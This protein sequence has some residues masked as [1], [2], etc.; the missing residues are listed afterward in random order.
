MTKKS[1]KYS[2][3][4]YFFNRF[5]SKKSTS[6]TRSKIKK[7]GVKNKFKFSWKKLRKYL[8]YGIVGI[9]LFVGILFAWY[10]KDLPTPSKLKSL[11][12][13]ESTKIYDR[14]GKLLYDIFGKQKRTVIKLAD[15]PQDIKDA[16]ISAEDKNFYHHYGI[17][18]QGTI[19]AAFNTLSGKR[20]EGGS[21][22]TQQFVKNALLS[23]E[24][25]LPRKI[26]E[27]ILALEIEA[28]YSKDEILEFYLNYIPFGGNTYGV[29]A[30]ANTYFNKKAG[31][32]TLAESATLAALVQAT[33]YYSP[34]GNHTDE[35]L[36]RKDWVISRMQRE[37]YI[38]EKEAEK[39][40]A[41]KIKFV[42]RREN[43]I[44]PHFVFYVREYLANK[45]GDRLVEEGGLKVITTLDLDKQRLAEKTIDEASLA[46]YGA[47]NAGLVAT[48]P[49]N[50]DIIAMVGSRDYFD[51]E[52]Q[53]NVNVTVAKRQ[54][55]SSFKPVVYA[56]GF[57]G[58]WA[59]GST[60]WDLKTTFGDYTPN[61]YDGRS[62]G[63]LSIRQSLANSLNI[64]AVKMLSLTGQDDVLKNASDLGITTFDQPE[65]YGLSLVLGG[66]EVKLLELTGAYA[67]FAA[68]GVHYPLNPILKLEDSTGKELE[69]KEKPKGKQVF[70]PEVAYQISDVLSDNASRGLIFGT[71][72]ALNISGVAAKTGT[73]D[74]YRDGWTVGYT[75]RVAVGVWT[76]NNDNS[77]MFRGDGGSVVAAPIWNKF[78]KAMIAEYGPQAFERPS[79]L[80]RIKVEVLSG[81]L[82][83]DSKVDTR[84]DWYAP[85]QIPKE[86]GGTVKVAICSI[87]NALA[88]NSCP[89][90]K[91][92]QKTFSDV[93][94]ERPDNSAWE[95]PVRNWLKSRGIDNLPPTKKD[96]SC[97]NKAKPSVSFVTPANNGSVSGGALIQVQT[98]SSYSIKRVEF[99]VDTISIG[100]D[101]TYPY[102]I[103]Y[104]FN[105][106]S[107]GGHSLKAKAT[108]TIDLSGDTVITINVVADN[109]APG[110]VV[111]VSGSSVGN[112]DGEIGLS[113]DNPSDY[114]ISKIYIYY[115]AGFSKPGSPQKVID[116]STGTT[117]SGLTNGIPYRFW[118]NAVD[119]VGNENSSG[120]TYGP[121][122]P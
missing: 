12:I 2:F 55:G 111:N 16:I 49:K 81:K 38:N 65:R 112:D 7:T 26:K 61:N 89:A 83:D 43:I 75:P 35:L 66:G 84:S 36:E 108:N 87:C 29:E 37:G 1:N 88:T 97:V 82:P 21:T 103:G 23:P 104:D 116:V 30:A 122:A 99:F 100:T 95:I 102:Q 107:I 15:M 98:N 3:Q 34:Y 33:T 58:E 39:G 69:K 14:N 5:N 22:I 28:I 106:L 85:W 67:S 53:G 91:V 94:S 72:T 78:M 31:D 113:W 90:S 64:P 92:V 24:Q 101:T 71:H 93:H 63:P 115:S 42:P 47:S 70:R 74:D 52:N 20:I 110:D 60:M 80:Q 8:L 40:Q 10:S 25:T 68:G 114:D 109:Q 9:L 120:I 46:A 50:G 45:Y 73:T 17:D 57:E 96:T 41:Q 4:K 56:T 11:K 27:L 13:S 79:T 32:L 19:R 59:P 6:R 86:K 119:S 48:D 105:Q 54:P 118:I 18:L 62:H 121:W 77:P 44:A 76:G 117:I 51:I